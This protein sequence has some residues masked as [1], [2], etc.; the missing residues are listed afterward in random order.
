MTNKLIV[1]VTCESRDQGE[2]V[3]RTLVESKL[4]A[5]VT[6]VPAI[7]SCYVWDGELIWSDEVLLMVK[8]TRER[9]EQLQHRVRTEHSY[10]VP[11]IVAVSITDGLDDYLQWIEAAV[12]GE[13]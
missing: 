5:C 2:K 3:A 12:G 11:E 13:G 7:R 8:T 9:F 4:A 6:V 10:E 1:F